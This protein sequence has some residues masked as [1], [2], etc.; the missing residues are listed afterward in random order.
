MQLTY[1]RQC[2]EW[3]NYV[4]VG[5]FQL[6]KTFLPTSNIKRANIMWCA[7]LLH[8]WGKENCER[9]QVK[10]YVNHLCEVEDL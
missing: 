1:L 8:N 9:N 2:S 7:I 10:T 5:A 4:L 3:G 6:L